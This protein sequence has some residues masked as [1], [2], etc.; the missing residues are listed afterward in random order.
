[1]QELAAL[2]DSIPAFDTAEARALVEAELGMDLEDVF[3][4]FG[5][6]PVAAASLAQVYRARLRSTGQEVAVKVQR[7]AALSTISKVGLG[8]CV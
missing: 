5:E 6:A 4:E 2:Q 7:P 3:S 1:M 8:S